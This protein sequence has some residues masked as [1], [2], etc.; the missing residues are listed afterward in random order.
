MKHVESKVVCYRPYCLISKR[1]LNAA[2]CYNEFIN[3]SQSFFLI[4]SSIISC[5]AIKISLQ[6]AF[7]L[8]DILKP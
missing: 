6:H 2:Q 5:E 4:P 3:L 8:A 1:M 7:I